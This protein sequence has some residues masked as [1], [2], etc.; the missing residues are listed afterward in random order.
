MFNGCFLIFREKRSAF[1]SLCD[2]IKVMGKQHIS[3]VAHK[4]LAS[5]KTSLKLKDEEFYDIGCQAWTNFLYR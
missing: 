3:S 2:L 5:L 4:V 1:W